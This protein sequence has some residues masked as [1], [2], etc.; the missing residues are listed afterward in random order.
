MI[1]M[2]MGGVPP[3]GYDVEEKC[4]LINTQEAKTVQ[5]IHSRYLALGCVRELKSELDDQ[6]IVSKI[7]QTSNGPTG[8]ESFSRGALYTILKN[9]LY[10]GMVAHKGSLYKGKHQPIL[11]MKTWDRVQALLASNRHQRQTHQESRSPSVLAGLLFDDNGNPMS[12]TH[13]RKGSQRYRYYISQAVLKF[14]ESE[15]GSVIRVAANIVEQAITDEIKRLLRSGCE[16]LDRIGN[17]GLSAPEQ[18]R[19]ITRSKSLADK[20]DKQKL[21]AQVQLL[22]KTLHKAVISRN[23]IEVFYRRSGLTQILLPGTP[24]P[25]P[26]DDAAIDFYQVSVPVKLKRCGIETRLIVEG[27]TPSVA[28]KRTVQ[29]VQDSLRK[30][31]QWNQALISG[32]ANSMAELARSEDVTQRYIAHI[33]KLA[34]L[35]PDIMDAIIKGNV[36]AQLSLGQLKKDIPLDWD[37]Q[38]RLFGFSNT[39]AA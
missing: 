35:A 33:I 2:W 14:R 8:G 30:A 16:L 32:K 37:E 36:P 19:L 9:P 24:G 11:D 39:A 6:G 15:A 1:D 27:E 18:E 31:L 20:W 34:Y 25:D 17:T 22:K 23:S 4:L 38:R 7:R 26:I 10:I 29:A 12:P 13:A 21:H 28:H 5:H 3:L